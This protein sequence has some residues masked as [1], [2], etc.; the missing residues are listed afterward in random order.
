MTR[1]LNEAAGEVI[2]VG[3]AGRTVY[4]LR[5]ALRGLASDFPVY[6][7]DR[8]GQVSAVGALCL[9][10]PAG[11][12][13]DVTVL[14]WPVADE[15]ARGVWPGLPYPLQDMCPQGFLGRGFARQHAAAL[16][17][18]DNPRQWGDDDVLHVLSQRVF[19]T[20]GN[21]IVGD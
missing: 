20:S 15:F 10:A 3:K 2:R 4:F 9:T 21:L 13:W 16:G 8:T 14:G 7:V 11:T 6:A 12:V 5:R 18:P 1:I 17:V 19:D